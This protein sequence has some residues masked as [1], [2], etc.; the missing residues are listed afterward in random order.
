MRLCGT[1]GY[2]SSLGNFQNSCLPAGQSSKVSLRGREETLG[3][4]V[5]IKPSGVRRQELPQP[6]ACGEAQDWGSCALQHLC[7]LL[8]PP[9]RNKL[10]KSK[11]V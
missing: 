5:S 7:I 9:S 3:I 1:Q 2:S 8:A 4:Q 10:F 11:S 6:S